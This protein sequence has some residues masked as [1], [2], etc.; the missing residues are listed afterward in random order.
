MLEEDE[1]TT[2]IERLPP[3]ELLKVQ[4]NPTARPHRR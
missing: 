4:G 2:D 3:A 1:E